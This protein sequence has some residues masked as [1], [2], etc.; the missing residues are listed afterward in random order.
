MAEWY[1]ALRLDVH[2]LGGVSSK[3]T[4]KSFVLLYG[5]YVGKLLTIKEEVAAQAGLRG[6]ARCTT[7]RRR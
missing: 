3:P 2:Q 6:L 7:Q 1:K 4:R 5:Q